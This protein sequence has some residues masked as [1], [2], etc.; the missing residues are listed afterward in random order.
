MVIIPVKIKSKDRRHPPLLSSIHYLQTTHFPINTS[1]IMA[2]RFNHWP[3][4]V[5]VYRRFEQNIHRAGY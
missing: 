3:R 1:V 5:F 4:L 2:F